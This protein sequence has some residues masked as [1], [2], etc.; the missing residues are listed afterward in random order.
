MRFLAF[1]RP[2][3]LGWR[4]TAAP[5]LS[6]DLDA[7]VAPVVVGR[8]DLDVAFVR[9][10]APIPSGSALG[11]E[12]IARVVDV[13]PRVRTVKPGDLVVLSAQICCGYCRSCQRGHTGRCESVPFAASYGMGRAGDFGGALSEL[14]RVPYADAM[15]VH[16]PAGLDPVLTIGAADMALDAWRAVGPALQERPDA[17]VLV[18]GGLA[19]V[20]GLYAAG[21]AVS[22]GASEVVY[23]D[24]DEQR[25][26]VAEKL[27]A[28]V[29]DVTSDPPRSFG[30]VVDAGGTVYGLQRA[31]A[32]AEPEA[33][34][35]SVV[36]YFDNSTPLPL[37]DMYQKGITF[38]TGRPN[39]R[40]QMESVLRLCRSG[41]FRPHDV[42]TTLFDFDHA[43]EAWLSTDLRIAV[44]RKIESS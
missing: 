1:E 13:G 5:K 34:F 23:W 38:R 10:A 19:S 37:R 3:V 15:L 8:C 4:E 29:L 18:V 35:T 7:I 16:L 14:L 20:I 27:G 21:L 17:A 31:L 33:L 11:H 36:I 44:E 39:V 25:R 30:I 26:K 22:M 12:C 40:A 6:S 9:G 43:D 41:C 32:A 28:K 2:G 42:P 24:A